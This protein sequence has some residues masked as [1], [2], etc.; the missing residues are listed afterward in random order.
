MGIMVE[1]RLGSLPQLAITSIDQL[2]RMVGLPLRL[3]KSYSL[4]Q[5][6]N[7]LRHDKKA[8]RQQP[9][10]VLLDAIGMP[11]YDALHYCHEVDND[12]LYAAIQWLQQWAV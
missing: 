9:R 1:S 7:C 4:E 11:R 10:F 6:Q 5:W 8:V 3:S 12:K 2:I